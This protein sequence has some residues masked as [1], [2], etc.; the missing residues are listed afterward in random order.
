MCPKRRS[1]KDIYVQTTYGRIMLKLR[2]RHFGTGIA[3]NQ[4]NYYLDSLTY[5]SS[6][7][8]KLD[9]EQRTLVV[10]TFDCTSFSEEGTTYA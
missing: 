7:V 6:C 2:L 1:K 9:S 8:D 5:A 4:G 3:V 10:T